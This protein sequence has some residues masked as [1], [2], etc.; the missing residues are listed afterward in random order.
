MRGVLPLPYCCVLAG[1]S[2]FVTVGVC[3]RDGRKENATQFANSGPELA[4]T[5]CGL[6]LLGYSG[7]RH[8]RVQETSLDPDLN[9]V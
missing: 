6:W 8:E 2:T 7:Q 5:G 9:L 4:K 3:R 1:S